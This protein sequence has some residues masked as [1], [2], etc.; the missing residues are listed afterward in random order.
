MQRGFLKRERKKEKK[1]RGLENEK[2]IGF[3]CKRNRHASESDGVTPPTAGLSQSKEWNSQSSLA[4]VPCAN[5]GVPLL[6]LRLDV[7]LTE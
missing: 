6:R 5:C 4:M 2:G 1:K 3:T 7:S